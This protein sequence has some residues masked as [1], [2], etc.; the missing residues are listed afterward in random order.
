MSRAGGAAGQDPPLAGDRPGP[1][2]GG[3]SRPEGKDTI[4]TD[5]YLSPS[6]QTV[7]PTATRLYVTYQLGGPWAVR[8]FTL[9]GK[10]LRPEA[11][12][13]CR[14]GRRRPRA[15]GGDDILFSIG[16]LRRASEPSYL[17]QAEADETVKLPL[18]FAAGGRVQRRRGR[19]RVRGQ[20]G[21]DESAG[22][23]PDPEG[24]EARRH[25]P[26]PGDRLR[27]LWH[28]ASSRASNPAWR[29]LFDHGFVVAVANL[30]GGAEY[31]RGVAHGREP[32]AQAERLRR[33]RRR[34][35][36]T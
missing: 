28:R 14:L 4:V 34:A 35:A 26:V 19:A 22:Q 6:R 7:L 2:E 1:V 32:D 29:V 12:E 33:L 8:C 30:R 3:G 17:Y 16:S 18:T 25:E 5:F 10:P 11:A 21:R 9:D 27:R 36:G 23:H 24:G 20:Q 31:R 13:T 15:A